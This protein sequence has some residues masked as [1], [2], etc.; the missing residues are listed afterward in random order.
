MFGVRVVGYPLFALDEEAT[1]LIMKETTAIIKTISVTSGMM[2]PV[3]REATVLDRA[4]FHTFSY[5]TEPYPCFF[6]SL[7][8]TYH[9]IS[10]ETK[11]SARTDVG[12]I[13]RGVV[14]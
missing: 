11:R 10:A 14:R 9:R 13:H 4:V 8:R 1:S 2:S 6:V 7:Y 3:V 5:S 12:R